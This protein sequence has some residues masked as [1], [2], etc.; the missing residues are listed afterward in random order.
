MKFTTTN[1]LGTKQ[2]LKF[3]DH[4]VAMTV[5][6]TDDGVAED[7]D[8]NK[9]VPMGTIVGGNGVLQNPGNPVANVR[10]GEAKATLVTA[11]T[12]KNSN[13]SYTAHAAGVAGNAI[14]IAY[15]DPAAANVALAVTVAGTVIT[16]NL[17]TDESKAITTT[18]GDIIAA[19]LDNAPAVA[20]VDAVPSGKLDTGVVNAMTATALAGGADGTAGTA[21]GVLMNDIDVTY[22]PALGAMIIH[23]F[24]DINKMP[25][26]PSAADIA[27]LRQIVFIG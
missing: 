21:E 18:A 3:P 16:I 11:C 14:K 15:L 27:A 10:A 22:G 9:I 1:Y 17:A 4:Y 26:K 7:S 25:D 2:I 13:I 19:I 20:L 12:A 8:G 24:I 5:T 23:G 6:V